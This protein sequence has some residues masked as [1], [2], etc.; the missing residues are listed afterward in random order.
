MSFLHLQLI[1]DRQLNRPI[2]L[3]DHFGQLTR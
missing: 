3:I 1:A 2:D